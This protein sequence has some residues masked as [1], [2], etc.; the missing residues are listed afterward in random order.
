MP[1]SHEQCGPGAPRP[2][3]TGQVSHN[4]K[5]AVLAAA[6]VLLGMAN[7]AWSLRWGFQY[8]DYLHQFVL[9]GL[10]KGSQIHVW[11]LYDFGPRGGTEYPQSEWRFHIWWADPDF[12]VRF[13]RPVTSLTI[14][15][16]Y[17]L[18]HNWA[19]GYHL[20]SLLLLGALLALTYRLYRELGA[21]PGAALWALAILALSPV[22]LVPVGW[23]ANR[24][25]VLAALLTVATVLM[26][27]RN[28]RT[29][30]RPYLLAGIGCF[31]LACGSKESGLIALPL[32]GLY[33]FLFDLR[34]ES[35]GF[36]RRLTRLITSPTLLIFALLAVSYLG[37]YLA[38]GYGTRSVV[39]P[40]PWGSPLQCLARLV[41]L[42][43]V[44]LF[45]LFF[46]F[47][48][49]LI[50]V[51]PQLTWPVTV[52]AIVL[53][54]A[55][56]RV[57]FRVVKP[58]PLVLFALGWAGLSL[59][60]ETG[61]DLSDRLLVDAAIGTSLLTGLFLCSLPPL[62]KR[63]AARQYASL[64]LGGVLLTAGV[65]SAI[66]AGAARAK[67]F[68]EMATL[69]RQAILDADLDANAPAPRSV[70]IV[71]CPSSLL[72]LSMSATWGV[73]RNDSG[74]CV[75]PLQMGRRPLIWK[76]EGPR[77]MTL[78]SKGSAFLDHRLERIFRT[79]DAAPSQ[80]TTFSSPLF[81]ATAL[82][83]EPT[84]IR[85]VRFE[86]KQN[87]DNPSYRFLIWRDGRMTAIKPPA[88]GQ[89]IELPEVRAL[90]PFAI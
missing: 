64:V 66:P 50:P 30:S 22:H 12:K 45:S 34:S 81:T 59:L 65:V 2:A 82:A 76:R 35:E 20:T 62:S 68:G 85:T 31:L 29:G 48:A 67:Y 41:V 39:Y 51:H 79:T 71:N 61:A 17:C 49:D 9:R 77:T 19:P 70:F 21:P 8:D 1:A 5:A 80:G 54:V 10:A 69:D 40:T 44:G 75:F 24:N 88:I 56:G 60:I 83:V 46:G 33:L 87:L 3:L 13:F 42:I 27:H 72:A 52:G 37:F 4:R 57:L 47:P 36:G 63:I 90:S 15:L 53:L 14:V 23:I 86:F 74:T 25:A 89:N 78:T 43:P 16:D 32:I 58:A 84:G 55:F 6:L 38:C 28:Q 7:N 73:A 18:Y 26:V 11:N